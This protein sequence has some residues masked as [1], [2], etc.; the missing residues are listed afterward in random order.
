[1]ILSGTRPA[2]HHRLRPQMTTQISHAIEYSSGTCSKPPAARPP[3]RPDLPRPG[4]GTTQAPAAARQHL[5]PAKPGQAAEQASGGK[6]ALGKPARLLIRRLAH[7]DKRQNL[8]CGSRFT[9]SIG[10][11]AATPFTLE[12]HFRGPWALIESFLLRTKHESSLLPLLT[13]A[14]IR[15]AI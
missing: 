8:R 5:L 12:L 15:N 3:P 4:H 6:A 9:Y 13:V 2:S 1:M 11:N 10:L 7:R 14:V